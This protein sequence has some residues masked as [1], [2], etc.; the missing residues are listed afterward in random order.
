MRKFT[1]VL[2][3]TAAL[4]I[5]L[6]SFGPVAQY[7]MREGSEPGHTGSPGDGS[8]NCTVCH[9]GVAEPVEGWITS[10]I[11]I[12]G[13]VP[14]NRYT[15]RARNLTFGHTRFGFQVSP[16]NIQGDLLG[17]LIATD[18]ITTKLVGDDKYITYRSAGVVGRDSMVWFFDWIAPN[19]SI[20][21]VVFYSA[22]NSNHDGHKGDDITQLSQLRVFKKGFTS[23][24]K[25]NWSKE[26]IVYPLPAQDVLFIQSPVIPDR[27]IIYNLEGKEVKSFSPDLMQKSMRLPVAD[28]PSGIYLLRMANQNQLSTTKISVQH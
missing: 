12:T 4:V 3:G 10:D 2:F 23:M 17:T 18:T 21:E 11:P 5:V 20:N 14:G 6:Q 28:L 1:I 19:D 15:I 25:A 24:A 16:Q 7:K 8:K 9:L 26:I 22:F 13:Y 27:I